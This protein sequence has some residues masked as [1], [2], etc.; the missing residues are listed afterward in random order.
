MGAVRSRTDGSAVAAAGVV[1]CLLVGLLLAPTASAFPRRFWGVVPQV[2]PSTPQLRRLRHGGVDSVRVPLTWIQASPGG[3]IEW[4]GTDAQVEAAVRARLE[5]LPFL[6]GAPGWAVRPRPVP[7]SRAGETAPAHLPVSGRAGRGWSAFVRAAVER[8][9]PRGS[10][11]RQ[12]RSLPKRPIHAWQIWNEENFKYFVARPD[13]GEYGRLVSRSARAIRAADPRATIVL[14]G[15]FARPREATFPFHPP[16]AYFAAGF[17]D[18]MYRR[19]PG[20]SAA[21]DDVALHPYTGS[22]RRLPGELSEVRRVLRRHGDAGKGLWLTELGWSSQRPS[23]RDSFAK[24]LRGQARQLK[25]A[26]GLLARGRHRW[27]VRR[28]YWFSVDDWPGACNF[29]GG[30]GLFRNRFRP[31]PAWHAYVRFARG[32]GR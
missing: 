27:R 18:R 9:G 21:F 23:G 30:T 32:R 5:I 24:G 7:G 16:R 28:V 17:L 29:C 6:Y 10:F 3:P 20:V 1:A 4:A 13:P 19:T 2:F 22:F 14:G 15:L 8:Y 25:G 31:K 12:H 26:F 11:W